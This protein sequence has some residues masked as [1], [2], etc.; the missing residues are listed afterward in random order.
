MDTPV[1]KYKLV[2]N[3]EYDLT[4]VYFA[5]WNKKYH[6][7]FDITIRSCAKVYTDI[8][9]A[10]KDKEILR[11]SFGYECFEIETLEENI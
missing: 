4:G 9:D 3:K 11:K 8:N 7:M 10:L 1:T 5:G 2:N 6:D